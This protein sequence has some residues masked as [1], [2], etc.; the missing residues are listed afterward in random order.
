MLL[1]EEIDYLREIRDGRAVTVDFVQLGLSPEGAKLRFRHDLSKTNGKQAARVIVL[2]GWMNLRTRRLVP[3]PEPPRRGAAEPPEGSAFGGP[4]R[5]R[6]LEEA[7]QSA[8]PACAPSEPASPG[9]RRH[10]RGGPLARPRL[11]R[12]CRGRAAASGPDRTRPRRA[13]ICS[14]R[15]TYPT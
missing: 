14:G 15:S 7:R 8:R 1:R 11:W 2:G 10:P 3:A 4:P 5:A 12:R 6:V 13:S 9:P